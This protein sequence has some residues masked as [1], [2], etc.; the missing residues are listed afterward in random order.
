MNILRTLIAITLL[1]ANF[2]QAEIYVV[3]HR[4]NPA[5]SLNAN[6]VRDLYLA[7]SQSLP[8]GESVI[9]YEGAEADLRSRFI[10]L[11]LGMRVRQFDAY[12]ARLIFAGRVLPLKLAKQESELF[13]HLANNV[14][15]IGYSDNRP[16]SDVLKTLLVI[17]E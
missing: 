9:V 2:C 11:A 13:T 5:Q 1:F 15:A 8:S 4:D 10:R 6:E 7:R 12:W 16:Q 17:N 14:H 3:T